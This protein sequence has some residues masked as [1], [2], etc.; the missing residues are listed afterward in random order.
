MNTT[1]GINLVA[2]LAAAGKGAA[3]RRLA[4]I[5]RDNGHPHAETIQNIA[6]SIGQTQGRTLDMSSLENGKPARRRLGNA[7][8]MADVMKRG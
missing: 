1:H 6:G 2:S 8:S 7:P 4:Q 3:A 5:L